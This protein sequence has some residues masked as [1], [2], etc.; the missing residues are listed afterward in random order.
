MHNHRTVTH[1][2]Y[3]QRESNS[4]L[5]REIASFVHGIDRCVN[6]TMN[7]DDDIGEGREEEQDGDESDT[8][9]CG[10]ERDAS[11]GMR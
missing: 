4:L 10:M 2:I 7:E 8:V 1:T 5:F 11:M 3:T 6:D 9:V